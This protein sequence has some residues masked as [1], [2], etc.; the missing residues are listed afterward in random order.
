M[1]QAFNLSQLANK[2]N[3]SGLLDASAGLYNQLPVANGGTG[4]SS[5]TSGRLLIGAGTSAMT[6]L[7]GSAPGDAVTWNGTT[8]VAGT[9]SGGP[10]TQSVYTSPATWTKPAT[11]VGI[12]VTVVGAGGDGGSI[13]SNPVN[14]TVSAGGGGGGGA[15]IEVIPASLIPGPQPVTAGSGSSSFGSF[16]SATPGANGSNTP[17]SAP[18]ASS[19]AGAGGTGSGG[20]IN[21][22]GQR[23]THGSSGSNGGNSIFIGGAVNPGAPAANYNGAAG[24]NRGGGGAGAERNASAS[25]FTGGAGSPGI[26]IIEE[27]Y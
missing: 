15:A 27:F 8:W 5:V 22:S 18:Y 17:S 7:A 10:P 14:S 25:A 20:D 23:G 26:V 3:S 6:E 11:L 12:K 19:A 1:T 13:P 16:C 2:V 9:V 21:F 24:F 4:K